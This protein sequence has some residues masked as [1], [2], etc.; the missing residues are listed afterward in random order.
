MS[1]FSAPVSV[2]Y[3]FSGVTSSPDVADVEVVCE[4]LKGVLGTAMKRVI[5]NS[6]E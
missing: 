5:D 2:L 4:V 1:T 6:N 3:W